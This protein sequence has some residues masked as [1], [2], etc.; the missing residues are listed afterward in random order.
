MFNDSLYD[1]TGVCR[2]GLSVDL[3]NKKQILFVPV[4]QTK[5]ISEAA[6]IYDYPMDAEEIGRFVFKFFEQMK[7]RNL[8]FH[9]PYKN[10]WLMPRGIR[11]FKKYV[12]ATFSVSLTWY[13]DVIK[14][15]R[16][17]PAHDRGFEPEYSCNDIAISASVSAKELGEFILQQFNYIEEKRKPSLGLKYGEKNEY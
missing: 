10:Y 17:F 13:G 9:T 1:T 12:E 7:M 8:T 3:I 16:W 2:H 11:S 15:C 6:T 14:V 5:V 4:L